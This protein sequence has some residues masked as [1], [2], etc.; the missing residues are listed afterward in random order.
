MKYTLDNSGLMTVNSVV[1]VI[2]HQEN[3]LTLSA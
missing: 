2:K 3:I 1:G